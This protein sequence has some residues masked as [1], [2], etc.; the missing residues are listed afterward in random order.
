M[1]ELP[2]LRTG[3]E[4]ATTPLLHR[5]WYPVAGNWAS[6]GGMVERDMPMVLANV[7]FHVG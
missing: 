7:A 3:D 1:T 2:G 4:Q 5:T 6:A